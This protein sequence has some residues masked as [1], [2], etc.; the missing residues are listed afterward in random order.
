VRQVG[1]EVVFHGLP[2]RP[3]KPILGAATASGKL[4]V[5]LPGNPVSATIGCDR[6]AVPL[7]AKMGGHTQWHP[8]CPVVRLVDAGPKT[9]PLHWMRLVRL[10]ATG[11]AEPVQSKGS[12]DL[13]SLG[14]STGYVEIP[15]NQSG[16][17]PW[18]YFAW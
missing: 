13:V 8:P 6:F 17:G 15:P 14:H 3:G 16:E 11:V 2:V 7:L 12:G 5:G 4:I 10:D 18:P 9:I 1:G